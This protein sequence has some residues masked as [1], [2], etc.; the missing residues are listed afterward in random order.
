MRTNETAQEIVERCKY[1]F[2]LEAP[3]S[4]SN[5]QELQSQ[6]MDI[7]QNQQAQEGHKLTP[8]C[9]YQLW[10]KTGKSEP[11][12]PLIGKIMPHAIT[13]FLFFNAKEFPSTLCIGTY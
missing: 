2:G 10:L 5:S 11:L 6:P 12:I 7:Q 4:Q 8:N 13:S 3:Q 9:S 1:L